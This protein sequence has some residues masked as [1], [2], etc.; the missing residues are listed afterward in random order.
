[1]TTLDA[2]GIR[3][4]LV[5]ATS[6]KL[7]LLEIFDEIDSTNSYLMQQPG[8]RSGFFRTAATLNQTAGRGRY[9]KNWHS[10]P[11]AGLCVSIAYAFALKPENLSALTLAIGLG[12][13]RALRAC[14]V[15]DVMLKWPNDLVLCDGKLGGILTEAHSQGRDVVGIVTG[16]GLNIDVGSTFND[17]MFDHEPGHDR[18]LAAIDLKSRGAELPSREQL[19]AQLM[20]EIVA[21]FAEYSG[22]G[23]APFYRR[24]PDHDWLRG[25]QVTVETQ[26]RIVSGVAAGID[27]DGALLIETANAMSRVTSGSVVSAELSGDAG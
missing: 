16:V 10:P 15:P 6:T 11:G 27:E 9:G 2:A 22:C 24:W 19:T 3:A 8:P 25:K 14:D 13:I 7:E 4:G 17:E 26:R 20:N 1:M 5:D 12:V 21:A 23:F 18:V